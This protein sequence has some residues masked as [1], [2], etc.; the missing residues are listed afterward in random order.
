MLTITSTA[1]GATVCQRFDVAGMSC[2]HC[3]MAV[4]AALT[5]LD[6]VTAVSVD[7]AGGTVTTESIGPLDRAEVGRAIDDA[8]YELV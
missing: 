5:A 1:T 8:G 4:T 2:H 3:E 6:N 7:V